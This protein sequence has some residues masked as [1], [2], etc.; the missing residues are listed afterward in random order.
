M[1]RF[2][3]N[4]SGMDISLITFHGFAYS[5]KT[6]LAKQVEVEG[7]AEPE[8]Q[9]TWSQRLEGRIQES[10][11]SELFDAVKCMFKRNWSDLWEHTN[12]GSLR[13][14][15]WEDSR[16]RAYARIAPSPG[17]V[18]IIFYTSAFTLCPS[19]FDQAKQ[20]IKYE[21]WGSEAWSELVFPL[22]EE[23]WKTHKGRLHALTRAV[24]EAWESRDHEDSA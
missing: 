9:L 15:L 20:A 3:A 19:E 1:V 8:R 6:L 5:G 12:V 7:T 16:W 4:N 10:G 17:K 13:L 14:S 18:L 23:G 11:V 22:D 24:Y 21:T 2:L